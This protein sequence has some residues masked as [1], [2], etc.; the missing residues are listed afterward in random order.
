M[1]CV[2]LFW[3][4]ACLVSFPVDEQIT[5]PQTPAPPAHSG[6]YFPSKAN[7]VDVLKY[8]YQGSLSSSQNNSIHNNGIKNEHPSTATPAQLASTFL[9]YHILSHSNATDNPYLQNTNFQQ[10]PA[11]MTNDE[12]NKMPAAD[13]QRLQIIN[14]FTYQPQQHLQVPAQQVQVHEISPVSGE[15][16]SSHEEMWNQY[17]AGG[18]LQQ[19]Q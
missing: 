4:V 1:K 15:S 17:N 16:D 3:F 2:L 18:Q 6:N 11:V 14:A 13:T 8:Y 19:S 12:F 10:R 5:P 7:R 9:Q